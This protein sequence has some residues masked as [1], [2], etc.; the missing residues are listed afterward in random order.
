MYKICTRLITPKPKIPK[1][2]SGARNPMTMAPTKSNSSKS[3]YS[4][5][6]KAAS[7]IWHHDASGNGYSQTPSQKHSDP[8]L[9]IWEICP[10]NLQTMKKDGS[11]DMSSFLIKYLHLDDSTAIRQ[12]PYVNEV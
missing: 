12:K 3:I 9:S 6:Q 7:N 11:V 4:S 5:M 1:R 2:R 10:Q 8:E